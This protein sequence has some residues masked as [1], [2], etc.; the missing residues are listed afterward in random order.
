MAHKTTAVPN[1]R[2]NRVGGE[3]VLDGVMM[4]AGKNC[5]TAVRLPNGNIRVLPRTYTPPKEKHKWMGLPIIRG[6]CNFISTMKLSL[7]VLTDSAEAA[8]GEELQESKS[9]AWMKKHL[10]FSLMNLVSALSLVLG[11]ALALALFIYLPNLV[12]TGLEKLFDVELGV[13]KAVTSGIVKIL[14]FILYI[15]LVSLMPDIRRTFQY[16]G[17]E[18]KTIACFESHMELTPENAKKCTRFHPRC[19]TSFMFVMILL[20]IILSLA[21][22][23]VLECDW[24][25]GIDFEYLTGSKALETLIYTGIGLLLLPLVMG[26]GYEFLMYAGKH[27]EK[28]IVKILSAPGLWMQRL[29]TREPNLEQLAVAIAATRHALTDIFPDFDRAAY[30]AKDGYGAASAAGA[31][32]PDAETPAEATDSA[33]ATAP[34]E[35]NDAPAGG[36]AGTDAPSVPDTSAHPDAPAGT[37][38]VPLPAPGTDEAL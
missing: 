38:E 25:F 34:A 16:H 20:G 5:S 31:D 9:D 11:I 23:A 29:T 3:A 19:G 15:Y 37:A 18:H 35:T 28:R 17:A 10:G 1:E 24:G 36:T 7:A 4:K 8:A 32:T 33:E 30:E 13:W 22:R 6:V 27:S 21:V 26:I 12:S 14:V 2:L